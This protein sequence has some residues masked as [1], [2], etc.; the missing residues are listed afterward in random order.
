MIPPNM[1]GLKTTGAE[2]ELDKPQGQR[3]RMEDAHDFARL[4]DGQ[5]GQAFASEGSLLRF[6]QRE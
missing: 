3:I 5:R 4:H 6:P 2:C 1:C